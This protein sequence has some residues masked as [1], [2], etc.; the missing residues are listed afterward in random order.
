ML[1]GPYFHRPSHAP[2]FSNSFWMPKK[3]YELVLHTI[4]QNCTHGFAS[5]MTSR[6]GIFASSRG[7]LVGSEGLPF[8]GDVTLTVSEMKSKMVG[9]NTHTQTITPYPLM[10]FR[11][12]FL[13]AG[14]TT[15]NPSGDANSPVFSWSQTIT[16]MVVCPLSI[17]L[18]H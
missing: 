15:Y 4:K 13:R 5:V 6:L 8:T 7:R 10:R 2:T 9:I 11:C 3:S 16:R 12:S 1:Q 14:R 17:K 18:T